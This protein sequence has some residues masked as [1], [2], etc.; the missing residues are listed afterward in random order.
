MI[1][2]DEDTEKY[3]LYINIAIIPQKASLGFSSR[4]HS[5]WGAGCRLIN[6]RNCPGILQRLPSFSAV[7]ARRTTREPDREHKRGNAPKNCFKTCQGPN[8]S[9]A[10]QKT[11]RNNVFSTLTWSGME[12]NLRSGSLEIV[13]WCDVSRSEI[14]KF[15][16]LLILMS[17]QTCMT[18][19]FKWAV[20]NSEDCAIYLQ[21]QW[22]GNIKTLE[23]GCSS[24]TACSYCKVS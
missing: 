18:L 20:Q 21:L 2:D 4:L 9:K 17:S 24:S 19:F 16:H 23:Q 3:G 15:F 5:L 6:I 22:M 1:K 10:A 11:R 14:R 7:Y 13:T 8:C 12:F